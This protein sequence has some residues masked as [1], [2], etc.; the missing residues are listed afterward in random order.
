VFALCASGA[1]SAFVAPSRSDAQ[2]LTRAFFSQH[3]RKTSSIRFIRVSADHR[4][5]AV[6]Y[7]QTRHSRAVVASSSAGKIKQSD[8]AKK[9][10]GWSPARSLPPQ[11]RRDLNA[12][13]Q[14]EVDYSG[15]ATYKV[16]VNKNDGSHF[17]ATVPI[18]WDDPW[19]VSQAA[20]SIKFAI[21]VPLQGAPRTD[22]SEQ[23]FTSIAPSSVADLRQS[24]TNCDVS[25][26][27]CK[28][29]VVPKPGTESLLSSPPGQNDAST[30]HLRLFA[31]EDLVLRSAF[32]VGS[33][34]GPGGDQICQGSYENQ[35]ALFTASQRMPYLLAANLAVPLDGLR[36]T[37]V[38]GRYRMPLVIPPAERLPADCSAEWGAGAQCSQS[39]TPAP[40]G[41]I[42]FIRKG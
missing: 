2:R 13:L 34:A 30:L 9:H 31:A 29:Q 32:A 24:C 5:A 41:T 27:D 35:P 10:G 42:Q 22:Y 7:E 28:A 23:A 8:Y 4:F 18:A 3:P 25:E 6:F 39:F 16:D 33:A 20:G 12:P 17:S 15:S 26:V 14:F 11:E 37:L 21:E 40:T 19:H 36:G 1:A 38:G